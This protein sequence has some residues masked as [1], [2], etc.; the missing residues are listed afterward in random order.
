MKKRDFDNLKLQYKALNKT[1][2]RKLL[3]RFFVDLEILENRI[4][5]KKEIIDIL[6]PLI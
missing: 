6:K 3:E 4:K 5:E 2:R 1:D